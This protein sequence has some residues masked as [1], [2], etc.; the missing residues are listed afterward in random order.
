M[1]GPN[2]Q[3]ILGWRAIAA[4]FRIPERTFRARHRENLLNSG[5]CFKIEI[6]NPPRL[7]VAS[8]PSSL[9]RWAAAMQRSGQTV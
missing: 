9:V 6:G 5:V 8:F 7:Y 3:C 2:E 1:C 4:M